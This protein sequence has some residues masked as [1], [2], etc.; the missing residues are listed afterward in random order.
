M[1]T[2]VT[3]TIRTTTTNTAIAYITYVN[4]IYPAERGVVLVSDR[5]SGIKETK[6]FTLNSTSDLKLKL[7][8][9][10]TAELR[11]VTLHWYLYKVCSERYCK[12]G[13]IDKSRECLSFT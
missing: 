7:G 4:T 6:P 5:D 8:I 1:T 13:S 12:E 10:A 2:T 9:T 3:S 11:F